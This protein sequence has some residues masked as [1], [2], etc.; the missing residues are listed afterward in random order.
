MTWVSWRKAS[1]MQY[2]KKWKWRTGNTIT[3]VFM[4]KKWTSFPHWSSEDDIK[5]RVLRASSLVSGDAH[6]RSSGSNYKTDA[7][8]NGKHGIPLWVI[9]KKYTMSFYYNFHLTVLESVES[10]QVAQVGPGAIG[11]FRLVVVFGLRWVGKLSLLYA[12]VFHDLKY[13]S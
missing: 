8:A 4:E 5:T 10:L 3:R 11:P 6:R 9:A 2:S 1:W 12:S 7:E 13:K